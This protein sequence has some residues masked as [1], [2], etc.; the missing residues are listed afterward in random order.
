MTTR[1]ELKTR[2][3]DA[4]RTTPQVAYSLHAL[5]E[6]RDRVAGGSAHATPTI[7]QY[8]AAE[9]GVA[10]LAILLG[11]YGRWVPIE[12]LREVAGVNRDGTS[13][14]N[15]LLTAA[16]Y[17]L[18]G[19]GY[20]VAPG[21][22]TGDVLPC[23]VFW[24]FNHF[25]V[26]E[27][28]TSEKVWINDPATGPCVITA[29]DFERA[30]T[31]VILA[32]EPGADFVP[33]G[34][35]PNFV[36]SIR[37]TLPGVKAPILAAV[38]GGF[39][40]VVPGLMIPGL[41][42]AF[43]DYY[44]IAGLSRWLWWLVGGIAAI[45][46]AKG[47][48]TFLQQRTLARFQVKLGVDTSGR[49]LWHIL[50]L[51][52]AFFAQ[53]NSGEITNRL[54]VSD[55][56]TGLLSGSLAVTFIGLLS[57]VI[58]AVV[59]LA[60]N[61]PLALVVIAFAALNLAL[62]V[63]MSRRLS[64]ANRRML[65]DEARMQSTMIH[66]FANLDTYRASGADNLFFR[67]WAG[68]HAKVV[69]A[70]Q[71]MAFW[72]RLLAGLPILLGTI[73]GACIVFIGGM[74]VMQGTVSIGMLVAFQALMANFNAPV[75]SVMGLT[76]Q[77]QQARGHIDRLGD[78]GRQRVDPILEAPDESGVIPAL[79]G[80]LDIQGLT[81]GYTT[82]TAPFL[83]DISLKAPA[84]GRVA[85][86][87]ATGSGK[88]TLARLMV[89]LMTPRDGVIRI[90]GIDLARLSAPVLR[91][92]VAYVDQTTTLFAGT[93]RENLTMWDLT[94]SED[95]VVAAARDAMVH[96][97]IASR[98][99]AYETRVDDNGRNFSAGERQRLA[100]AR[101]L[102]VD[103]VLIVFDEAMS[104]LDSIAEQGIIDNIRRRGCTCILISHRISTLRDC[105]EIIVLDEGRIVER[106]RHTALMA[107]HRHYQKQVEA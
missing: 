102:A 39:L 3:I 97:M 59:M 90:D 79:H 41:Q 5:H 91:S 52:M 75:T 94:I 6:L 53:R 40:L 100:I 22:L 27:R 61:V 80:A 17:G 9:C 81:F 2:I 98:P 76:A 46:L 23:I 33:G 10:C 73:A 103:P 104:S 63:L 95:R 35:A 48:L 29:Q 1:P 38:L 89:G 56:L 15:L 71:A 93:V 16:R 84:G 74:G 47:L 7:L 14:N 62:L 72:Q 18:E 42:R 36:R 77:L 70:E 57:I 78:V 92:A 11:Y 86:T 107:A 30:F 34:E 45:A 21:D 67:R 101:A 88:S 4:V 82:V 83:R 25:V 12:E 8:E 19:R 65:Q 50:R 49:V 37:Q 31:G 105:D 32:L 20:T 43:V 69:S 60:Y 96:E 28:R 66:G 54:M 24:E 68:E 87:G 99:M 26:V 106:G 55:R 58:Y 64:D 51:P 13:A 85:I 44:M